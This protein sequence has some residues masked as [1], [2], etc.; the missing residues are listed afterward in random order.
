[1]AEVAIDGHEYVGDLLDRLVDN[2]EI[3]ETTELRMRTLEST[4][5][6]TK[7]VE[8]CWTGLL[9]IRRLTKTKAFY[10]RWPRHTMPSSGQ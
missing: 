10:Y 9:T 1:M 8:N 3:E 4:S 5:T 2:T 6:A 7:T